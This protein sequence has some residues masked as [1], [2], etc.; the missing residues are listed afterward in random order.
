M[1]THLKTNTELLAAIRKASF[2]FVQP[3]FGCSEVWIKISKQEARWFVNKM[4]ANETPESAEMGT[5]YF[6][7]IGHDNN[8]YLG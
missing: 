4:L 7:T 2:V 6:G 8:L 1:Q 5:D 3:R